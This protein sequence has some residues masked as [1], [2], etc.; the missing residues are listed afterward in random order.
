[1]LSLA[2]LHAR[3]V[4]RLKLSWAY[5][6]A[7]DPA[8]VVLRPDTLVAHLDPVR[9]APIA[10]IGER[11]ASYLESIPEA[12]AHL[13]ALGPLCL[14]VA[15]GL[16]PGAGLLAAARAHGVAVLRAAA[17]AAAVTEE[18][19]AELKSGPSASLHGVFIEVMGV[20]VLLTGDAAVGKSELALELVSRGHR[21]IADDAPCF[22]RTG[23]ETVEGSCAAE[24]EDFME[25]RG[26]GIINVRQLYGDSAVK[27]RRLLRL[28]IALKHFTGRELAPEERLHGIRSQRDVLGV[29]IPEV[30]LPVAPGRNLAV[31]T[32]CTVRNHILR[33]KGYEAAEDLARRQARA[34]SGAT[35]QR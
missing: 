33:A 35:R 30:T 15:D 16:E 5:R 14:V 13:C 28:I 34:M 32:E 2:T 10:V 26:L 31:L 20:G 25:V 29:A 18:L 8:E 17:S 22:R 9:P 3:Q 12:A 4:R 27:R 23:P 24:L 11:E 7:R 19:A 6:G 21:L 1:V